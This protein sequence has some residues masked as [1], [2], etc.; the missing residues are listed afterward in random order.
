MVPDIV[1]NSRIEEELEQSKERISQLED[2]LQK[3]KIE[4]SKIK[5]ISNKDTN[6]YYNTPSASPSLENM[7]RSNKIYTISEILESNRYI[8][9]ESQEDLSKRVY[10]LCECLTK[11]KDIINNS[12]NSNQTMD[13]ENIQ[14]PSPPSS[15]EMTGNIN[16]NESEKQFISNLMAERDDTLKK[17]HQLEKELLDLQ[18]RYNTLS[19]KHEDLLINHNNVIDENK[20]VDSIK[21]EQAN[22]A[23]KLLQKQFKETNMEINQQLEEKSLI[24]EKFSLMLEEKEKSLN[25]SNNDIKEK[26]KIINELK[27]QLETVQ[28]EKINEVEN[29]KKTIHNLNNEKEDLKKVNNQHRAE[30]QSVKDDLRKEQI[31]QKD[32]NVNSSIIDSNST[33]GYSNYEKR[34]GRNSSNSPTHNNAQIMERI[35]KMRSEVD[36]MRKKLRNKSNNEFS[37]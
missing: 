19:K 5:N 31:R 4:L 27:R 25:Q 15:I 35:S 21:Q 3:S 9:E 7:K 10:W 29:L 22:E 6:N 17:Q 2:E 1:Q 13:C 12:N 23:I 24:I 33:T 37:I 32:A 14:F 36:A 8:G 28:K 20:K 16:N 11:C 18:N 26:D 30:L 34:S